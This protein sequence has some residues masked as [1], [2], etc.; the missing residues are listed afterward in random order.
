MSSSADVE[1]MSVNIAKNIRK[2]VNN[3]KRNGT[4]YNTKN[5]LLNLRSTIDRAVKKA[6]GN[7]TYRSIKNRIKLPPNRVINNMTRANSKRWNQQSKNLKRNSFV[8]NRH[9]R[10]P[11]SVWY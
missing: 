2:F 7:T 4:N 10:V 11:R 5:K 1:R 8:T 9:V 3:V 6:V